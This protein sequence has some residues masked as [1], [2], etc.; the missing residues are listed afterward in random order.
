MP[1]SG[2]LFG[3]FASAWVGTETASAL[4][5]TVVIVNQVT[6]VET[7][8][9]IVKGPITG[10]DAT[11][12]SDNPVA[13]FKV[14]ATSTVDLS[15]NGHTLTYSGSPTTSTLPNGNTVA[16]FNGSTQY[17]EVTDSNDLSIPDLGG[18]ITI[19][20]WVRFDNLEQPGAEASADG[21]LVHF[22]GK[23]VSGQHE[24][25]A[26]MY[27]LSSSLRSNRI[28]GY[29]FNAAGGTGVGSYWQGSVASTDGG[30]PPLLVAGDWVHYVLKIDTVNLGVDAWGT[31][32]I[33]RNGV[34]MDHDTLAGAGGIIPTNG[35]APFRIG[36]RDFV[37][38]FQGA[39]GKV[40]IYSDLS[41]ARIATHYTAMAS[42]T[43]N[44]AVNQITETDVAQPI[45]KRK[46][47][48]IGQVTET[49]TPQTITKRKIKTVLQTTETDSAQTISKSKIKGILQATETD[50]PQS[51]TKRKLRAL[52][53]IVETDS[54][55]L[56]TKLSTGRVVNQVTETDT[57]QTI[58]KKKI[59]IIGQV[60]ETDTTQTIT[61]IHRRTLGQPVETD[62]VTPIGKRKVK[63]T[64]QVIETDT[65]NRITV[66]GR[67]ALVTETDF[68]QP[69][70]RIKRKTI[71]QPIETSTAQSIKRQKGRTLLQVIEASTATTITKR[72]YKLIGIATQTNTAFSISNV[73]AAPRTPDVVV[74][75][76]GYI[77]TVIADTTVIRYVFDVTVQQYKVD[78]TISRYT[79]T[80]T[81]P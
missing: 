47:I 20:A 64:G 73:L 40:A 55:Q 7:A 43:K 13:Y 21:P 71:G 72:K 60:V 9:G 75:V 27:N 54:A 2:P 61:R 45:T 51:I 42:A 56:I 70:T 50:T 3:V 5:P 38:F 23:G 16:V 52:A 78:V 67:V 37:S 34:L 74:V 14:D 77:F 69:I 4:P 79:I 44:V 28:S 6:E 46:I 48:T 41:D 57:A 53:Q 30:T 12:L 49:D 15:G 80:V 26:R 62:T 24:Y 66:L 36:T 35:T 68:A 18:I 59:K 25:A 31:T 81:I 58:T 32:R 22:M 11:V 17:A 65:A 33:Y 1:V 10:Y 8:R 39:I 19:E 76:G 29:A 63:S